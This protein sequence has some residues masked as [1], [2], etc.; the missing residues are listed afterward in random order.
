MS[1]Q[2]SVVDGVGRRTLIR[3]VGVGVGGLGLLGATGVATAETAVRVPLFA[4]RT[5][6]VGTV[7]V[8]QSAQGEQLTVTYEITDDNWELV[9]TNLFVGDE[10]PTNPGGN[11]QVGQFTHQSEHDP[12]V[13]RYT[14]HV[15]GSNLPAVLTV[16]AQA[17]VQTDVPE[18][19]LPGDESGDDTAEPEGNDTEEQPTDRRTESAW[20]FGARIN[21][22][23]NPQGRDIGSW[24]TYFEVVLE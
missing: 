3:S 7:A 16:A 22:R 23:E 12:A 14:H 19:E 2:Q 17:T 24:A 11:P 18:D 21:Q 8:A 4:A 15:D 1:E 5:I 10:I 6:Q 9:E 13:E 20:G